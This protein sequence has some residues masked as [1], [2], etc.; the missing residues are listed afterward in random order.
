MTFREAEPISNNSRQLGEV[1]TISD[2]LD[3]FNPFQNIQG[4][5]GKLNPGKL[6]RFQTI[7][8]NWGKLKPL[9]T[10]WGRLTHFEHFRLF[11]ED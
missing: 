10:F 4:F 3:E 11:W 9:Q 1:K 2:I 8:D 6:N 7:Q 5:I